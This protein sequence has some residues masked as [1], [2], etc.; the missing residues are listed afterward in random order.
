MKKLEFNFS[1]RNTIEG[2][3]GGG[4]MA[5]REP[6]KLSKGSKDDAVVRAHVA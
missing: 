5:Q 1:D 3:R 6:W 2:G 4:E